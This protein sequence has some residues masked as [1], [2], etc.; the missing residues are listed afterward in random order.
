MK[1]KWL[2][3]E[4]LSAVIKPRWGRFLNFLQGDFNEARKCCSFLFFQFPFEFPD[5]TNN[6]DQNRCSSS[7][8]LRCRWHFI[9]LENFLSFAQ[10]CLKVAWKDCLQ[11]EIEKI[12][13]FSLGKFLNYL[14]KGQGRM[15]KN[16]I[17]NFITKLTKQQKKSLVNRLLPFYIWRC[18]RKE[19]GG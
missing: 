11:F 1:L 12:L 10:Q 7:S 3:G 2:P 8:R 17:G 4:I 18:D 15:T 9:Q 6:K 16:M 13:Y 14:L 19:I 5:A